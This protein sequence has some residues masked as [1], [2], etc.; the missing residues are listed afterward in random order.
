EG[1]SDRTQH[2]AGD[3]LPGA[4]LRRAQGAGG[5]GEVPGPAAG[6]PQADQAGSA[7]ALAV[8][9]Q[10]QEEVAVIRP[11]G[12]SL[13]TGAGWVPLLPNIERVGQRWGTTRESAGHSGR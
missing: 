8:R 3:Y 9:A 11:E 2:L 5:E 10:G 1:R 12:P 7:G 13:A 4:L 6:L